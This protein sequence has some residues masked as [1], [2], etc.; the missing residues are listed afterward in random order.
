MYIG[1]IESKLDKHIIRIGQCDYYPVDLVRHEL[2][3]LEERCVRWDEEDFKYAAIGKTSE[4]EWQIYYDERRF[5][6]ALENMIQKHDAELG[7]T[8]VTVNYYLDEYCKIKDKTN[9]YDE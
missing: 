3:Y 4:T 7:I 5:S 6:E 8:W 9:I 2:Q 1:D